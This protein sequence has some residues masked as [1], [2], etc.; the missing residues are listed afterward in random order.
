MVVVVVVVLVVVVSSFGVNAQQLPQ[1][2]K[3]TKK[4]HR[5]AEVIF[6][7]FPRK[8]TMQICARKSHKSTKDVKAKKSEK[9]KPGF[10][11]TAKK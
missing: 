5:T 10:D 2:R 11:F 4:V 7:P 8:P 9:S 1:N 3:A 6:Y